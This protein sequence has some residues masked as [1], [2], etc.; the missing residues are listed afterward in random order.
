MLSPSLRGFA[1]AVAD[2]RDNLRESADAV[3]VQVREDVDA[4]KFR[5]NRSKQVC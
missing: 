3:K 5:T 4:I 2:I 1:L